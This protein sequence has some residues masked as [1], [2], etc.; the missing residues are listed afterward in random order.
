MSKRK[1]R[2]GWF[3]VV[4]TAGISLLGAASAATVTPSDGDEKGRVDLHPIVTLFN[5]FNPGGV[6]N[7][8]RATTTFTVASATTIT[9][10]QT[11]HWNAG[12]GKTPGTI[13]L[14][15]SDGKTYGPWQAT[16]SD[17]QGGVKSAFWQA[18]PQASIPA[19]TYTIVDS[20]PAT[21]SNNVQSGYRGFALVQGRR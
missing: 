12:R 9:G 8:P 7:Q 2:I 13:K 18:Y 1:C 20:D 16:G 21:W 14:T 4:V 5:N 6:V 10:V 15:A 17:G 19:G 3:V 11:Y